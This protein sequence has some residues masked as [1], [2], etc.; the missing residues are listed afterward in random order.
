MST[1]APAAPAAPPAEAP[2]KKKSS[3]LLVIGLAAIVLAGGGGGAY[4]WSTR[5][6]AAATEPEPKKAVALHERGIVSFEPFVVNL[7]DTSA[8]RF[9]RATIRLVVE[10]A[11]VA[12]ELQEAP[13]PMAQARAT[14]LDL[15]TTQT[16]DVL[17]TPDGKAALRGA[18]KE[19][20]AHAAEVEV[21]DVLFSD[22][23]VQ[24]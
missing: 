20:V 7:A 15:L 18:I 14:I 3:K 8:P 24:F 12:K 23:V 1:P 21:V 19:H 9:L 17:V 10:S 4:W 13:A 5:A 16:A 11:E 2:A 22:F 6:A